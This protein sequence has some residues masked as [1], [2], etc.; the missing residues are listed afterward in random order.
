M[1]DDSL[2]LLSSFFAEANHGGRALDPR[3]PPRGVFDQQ[4][5]AAYTDGL[6]EVTR[7]P[8]IVIPFHQNRNEFIGGNLAKIVKIDF[9]Y[10][11][12]L[13]GENVPEGTFAC[14]QDFLLQP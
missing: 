10:P 8:I 5:H 3:D 7:E 12:V 9:V 11:L 13:F 14:V 4:A 1:L 6:H 2:V